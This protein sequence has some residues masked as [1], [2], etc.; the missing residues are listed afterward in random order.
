[1][2]QLLLSAWTLNGLGYAAMACG[3]VSSAIGWYGQYLPLVSDTENGVARNLI[4]ARAAEAL[5]AGG[6]L[7][8]AERLIDD[9]IPI[10]EFAKA[11]HYLALARRVQA[12]LWAA[13]QKYDE[14]FAALGEAIDIF[15]ECG[16]GLEL[17]RALYHRAL[18]QSGTGDS[19]KAGSD[20]TRAHDLFAAMGASRDRALAERLVRG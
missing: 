14:A 3:D 10:A 1:M 7:H 4:M 11:P 6:Q 18:L 19:A 9:A 17:A 20:A 8:E 12:Q 15:T 16:S 13:R 2:N 5:L